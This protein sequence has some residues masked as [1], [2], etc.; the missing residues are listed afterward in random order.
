MKGLE[1]PFR[2]RIGDGMG[3]LCL[4]SLWLSFSPL[5]QLEKKRVILKR[6]NVYLTSWG[7]CWKKVGGFEKAVS[8][9]KSH[10]PSTKST[11]GLTELR[12]HL[13]GS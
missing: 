1:I 6:N 2:F 11:I 13:D 4:E 5:M 10:Y 7:L 12:M 9:K 3:S 8:M